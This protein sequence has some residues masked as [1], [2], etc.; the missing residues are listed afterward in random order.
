MKT[1]LVTD[2][3]RGMSRSALATVR[4]LGS[5]GHRVIVTESGCGELAASS[6]HAAAVVAVPTARDADAFSAA[7]RD[8]VA[9][10]EVLAVFAT[11]DD[12]VVALEPSLERLVDKAALSKE[13]ARLGIPTPPSTTAMTRD[14]LVSASLPAVAKPLTGSRPARILDSVDDASDLLDAGGVVIQLVVEGPMTA[15]AGVVFDGRLVAAVHQAYE[16]TWPVDCGTASSAVTVP[17][18]RGAEALLVELLRGHDGIFQAQYIDGQLIDINPRPYGSMSLAV[19]AGCNLPELVIEL[20]SGWRP[21]APLRAREGVRY[22][23]IEGDLRHLVERSRGRSM[24]VDAALRAIRPRRRT[25]HS[26]ISADDPGP[27]LHRL[28]HVMATLGERR[29]RG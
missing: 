15:I 17:P 13:L 6:R 19:A 7:I 11:S 9:E 4:A 27:G 1:A 3:G 26:V 20:R 10:H 23:W 2:G 24:P 16:R 29:L 25:A 8:Q 21:D 5:A 28:R 14:D 12:A 22:R 18:D